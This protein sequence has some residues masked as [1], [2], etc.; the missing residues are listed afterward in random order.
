MADAS[1]LRAKVVQHG[2]RWA[3]RTKD[4]LVDELRRAAPVGQ[5][6]ELA[7]TIRGQVLP[8]GVGRYRIVVEAPAPQA[9]WTD[10]G[11]R[12]HIIRPRTKKALAFNWP[13]AGGKV[14]FRAVHHPG[15][16]GT[17]WWGDVW[18]RTN[19]IARRTL[20]GLGL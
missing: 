10:Q 8:G 1:G 18:K 3:L 9:S 13:K 11:T 17:H 20:Q 19:S 7:R 12:P 14:V 15:N 4:A 5:S 2:D 16:K 6:G